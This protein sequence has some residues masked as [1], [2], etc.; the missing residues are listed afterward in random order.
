[1]KKALLSLPI[2]LMA[3]QGCE[4]T[5][6]S[7]TNSSNNS[8]EITLNP[9]NQEAFFASDIIDDSF[10]G[11]TL[12]VYKIKP[13]VSDEY[14]V[15]CNQAKNITIYDDNEKLIADNLLDGLVNLSKNKEYYFVLDVPSNVEFEL[16]IIAANQDHITPYDI[17]CTTDLSLYNTDSCTY[18][19]LQEAKINYVKREG[20]TYLYSNTPESMPYEVVNTI[21]MQNK[22]LTGECFLTFEHQNKTSFVNNLYMGYRLKNEEDH[23]I[24]VTVTNV[25]YQV[26]GSWLGEKAW[27]DYYG[28]TYDYAKDK[29]KEGIVGDNMNAEAYFKAYFNFEENYVPNVLEPVTYKLPKG[30]YLYI[31]GG[32]TKDN[33]KNADIGHTADKYLHLGHCANGNVKF[34]ISNGKAVGELCVYDNINEVNKPNV[35]VQNLRKYSEDDTLGGRIGFSP[36]HGVIDNSFVW[37][38]NDATERQQLPVT[39]DNYYADTL[40]AHY[41]PLEEIADVKK[42]TKTNVRWFTNLSAQLSHDYCGTDMVDLHAIYEGKEIILSNYIANPV[43][44]ICDFGNWMIEYQDNCTLVNK[45]DKDRKFS[46]YINNTSAVFY[47]VKEMDGTILKAGSHSVVLI[48]KLPFFEI[49][50]PAH[51]MKTISLQYVLPANAYGSMEHYVTLD[52]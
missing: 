44:I 20:G 35:K 15:Y 30:E 34:F 19:P 11:N 16:K 38:V 7:V 36:I 33:Y 22:D 25:G 40:K 13:S 39:Y 46:F 50:I 23:D 41:E 6:D 37:Q 21:L 24:Y 51:T 27:M 49:T 10:D 8:S 29:F 1:M 47:I 2:I 45:G 31:L 3:L 14:V 28:V 17:N 5:D 52:N 43:G 42:H 12:R 18:S 4:F 48:G 26:D 9:I 32:T